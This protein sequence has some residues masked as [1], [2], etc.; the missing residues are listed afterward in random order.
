MRYQYKRTDRQ[1]TLATCYPQPGRK[2]GPVGHYTSRLTRKHFLSLASE[3][4]SLAR[5]VRIV[6]S[7]AGPR[8]VRSQHAT[9][10]AAMSGWRSHGPVHGAGAAGGA[11][12]R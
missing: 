5:A 7:A 9:L 4:H 2:H 10:K 8:G 1:A 3:G 12:L 11:G 6:R